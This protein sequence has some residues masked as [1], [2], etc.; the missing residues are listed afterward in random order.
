MESK[1]NTPEM[2]VDLSN[3][4]P[5]TLKRTMNIYVKL[6]ILINTISVSEGKIPREKVRSDI[7]NLIEFN[8]FINIIKY[9]FYDYDLSANDID[10]LDFKKLDENDQRREKLI[11]RLLSNRDLIPDKTLNDVFKEIVSLLK[12]EKIELND[13]Q[14]GILIELIRFYRDETQNQNKIDLD[15]MNPEEFPI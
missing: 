1:K 11:K 12:S 8:T 15:H 6:I 3:S 2:L 5:P 7:N 14:K 13:R 10:A 9:K 4:S